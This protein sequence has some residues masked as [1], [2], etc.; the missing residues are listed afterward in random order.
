[1]VQLIHAEG[2]FPGNDAENLRRL[3]R[4]L[5]F[6]A[7]P[8]GLEV[9]NFNLIFPDSEIILHKVLGERVT[10]DPARSGVL[11]RPSGDA[12]WFEHFDSTEEWCFVVALEP[13]VVNFYHHVDAAQQLG[14]L[15]MADAR[16]AL[17]G[18]HYNFNNLFEWKIHTNIY[19]TQNQC[20]F[21]RP[22]VFHNLHDGLIQYYR[23]IAD[24][25]FRV[26]V[27]G[28]PGSSRAAVA[29]RLVEILGSQAQLL[30]SIDLR[31][32][33]KD[34]D[35]TRDGQLRHCYRLLNLAR[36]SQATITVID[37]VC[38]LAKMRDILNAD[39]VIWCSDHGESPY[40]ELNDMFEPPQLYDLQC[41]DSTN[42]TLDKI[43][44]RIMSVRG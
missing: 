29:G 11:R 32:S 18:Q 34:V 13:T 17:E 41:E 23:L 19:L 8:Y 31:H 14:D 44:Q 12:V 4:A 39:V 2:F 38:P 27:M 26:L 9:E 43:L 22:W 33:N 20:L 7:K 35:F 25:K 28:M 21:F 30:R 36:A 10:V 1:M 42:Q 5:T 24:V 16:N 3:S 15:A 6:H 40:A 37:M